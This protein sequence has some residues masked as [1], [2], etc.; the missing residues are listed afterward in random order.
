MTGNNT[1]GARHR[2]PGLQRDRRPAD[3]APAR[4]AAR[5]VEKSPQYPGPQSIWTGPGPPATLQ[6]LSLPQDAGHLFHGGS[7][8]SMRTQCLTL[9]A[10]LLGLP[11]AGASKSPLLT[12]TA[13]SAP[14]FDGSGEPLPPGAV[15]RLG[16]ARFYHGG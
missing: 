3:A 2:S 14:R 12:R 13:E 4:R 16:E 10:C 5:D 8:M 11:A 1:T 6:G 15:A 7:L 9:L